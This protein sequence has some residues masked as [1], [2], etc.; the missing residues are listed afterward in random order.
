MLQKIGFMGA[1]PFLVRAG[2]IPD[3]QQH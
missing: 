3:I 2:S 1:P